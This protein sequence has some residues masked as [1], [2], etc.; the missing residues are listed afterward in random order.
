MTG[1]LPVGWAHET[2]RQLPPLLERM[3]IL[4]DRYS[5]AD[6]EEGER[7]NEQ[8]HPHLQSWLVR[9]VAKVR[10]CWNPTQPY[11]DLLRAVC[12]WRDEYQSLIQELGLDLGES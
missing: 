9:H 4:L 5:W 11:N 3:I 6:L 10:H 12:S 8:R 7:D 2:L 1:T